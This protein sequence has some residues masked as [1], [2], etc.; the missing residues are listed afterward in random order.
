MEQEIEED[1]E[2]GG[3]LFM[4]FYI[5]VISESHKREFE[6]FA[7][8]CSGMD[9]FK[10]SMALETTLAGFKKFKGLSPE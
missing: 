1:T 9:I 8:C 3:K 6:Q 5:G 7:M 2:G 4:L 10:I